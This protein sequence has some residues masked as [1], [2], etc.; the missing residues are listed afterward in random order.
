MDSTHP[1][2]RFWDWFRENHHPYLHY[3][4]AS[5]K[6]QHRLEVILL[7]RLHVHCEHLSFEIIENMDDPRLI[8][9]ITTNGN[10]DYFED[11]EAVVDHAPYEME[12]W[13]FYN[14]IPPWGYYAA[15]VGYYYCNIAL[16]IDQIWFKPIHH[17]GDPS[18]LAFTIYL[19]F[20]K[21]RHHNLP[22][23]RQAVKELLFK[24]IGEECFALDL[25]YFEIAQLPR[26]PEKKGIKELY[27][28]N[29]YIDWHKTKKLKYSEN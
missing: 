27:N 11:A 4:E 8:F 17:P 10:P 12:E 21:K 1:Q 25:R 7:E 23:L 15:P 3:L 18:I 29:T 20:Y 5:A 24:Y 19:K 26:R 6:E 22:Y 2:H 28:L 16:L 14:L 9:A 13:D